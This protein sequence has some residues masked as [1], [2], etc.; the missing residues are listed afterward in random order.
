MYRYLKHQKTLQAS[1][2][3]KILKSPASLSP[4]H[5]YQPTEPIIPVELELVL[6]DLQDIQPRPSQMWNCD[7]IG[8]DSNYNWNKMVFL[9]KLFT[10]D[11]LW[12]TQT[13]ESAPFCC[14][15]L[16]FACAD[17]QCYIPPVVVHQ[18]THYS[19]D[20]NH[21]IPSDW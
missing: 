7:N 17:G 20:L 5:L 11:R 18:R 4:P 21:N 19:Q 6:P 10:G 3:I 1:L 9:Y 13:D 14:T 12:R 8:V 15:A 2:A 16:I